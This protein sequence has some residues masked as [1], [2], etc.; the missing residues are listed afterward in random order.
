MLNEYRELAS[1]WHGGQSS[2][3]YAYAS[4]DTLI[5]AFQRTLSVNLCGGCES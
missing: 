2:A 1:Q 5:K 4:T 3:L